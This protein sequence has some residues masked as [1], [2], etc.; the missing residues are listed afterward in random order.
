MSE[1]L[2]VSLTLFRNLLIEQYR[3]GEITA[4]EAIRCWQMN[5]AP[6]IAWR[7]AH[8]ESLQ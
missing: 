4:A 8:G 3:R 7:K 1:R 5:A 6:E 2:V